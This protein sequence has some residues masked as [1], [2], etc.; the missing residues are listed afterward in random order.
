MQSKLNNAV[1]YSKNIIDSIIKIG[2]NKISET[3]ATKFLGIHLEK[4]KPF[5]YTKPFPSW[6]YS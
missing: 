6:N 1:L 5:I 2:S 3:S 4:K